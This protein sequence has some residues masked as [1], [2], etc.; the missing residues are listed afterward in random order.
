MSNKKKKKGDLA[1]MGCMFIGMG[2]GY[3]IGKFL[4]CMFIGMG[5]GFLAQMLFASDQ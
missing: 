2:C 4:V 1:F 5:I 3:L